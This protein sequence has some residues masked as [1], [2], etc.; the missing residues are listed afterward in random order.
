M[1]R[2]FVSAALSLLLGTA[3]TLAASGTINLASPSGTVGM[4]TDGTN[5]LNVGMLCGA[6]SATLYS[7]CVNQVIVN[8]SGQMLTMSTLTGTLP[9]FASPPTIANTSFGIS[10]TLPAFASNPTIA[11]TSFGIS[12]TLPAFASTPTVTLGA[13][14]SIAGKFGIDQTTPGTTNG[15][16]LVACATG[17]CGLPTIAG[18]ALVKG[19][20]A[21][22][23]GTTS[24]QV[25]AA[26]SSQHLY[27][28]AIHCN[29][30]GS[31][32][33]LVNIQDGSGGTTLDT[34]AAGATFGGDNRNGGSAPLFWTTAGNA[35]FAADVTTGASVIC[36]ASGY[37][38]AN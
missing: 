16:D 37:S 8:S 38:S 19:V 7:T 28:T 5:L 23:T 17:V 34:L 9:A 32:A 26:V 14:S 10:G 12:G 21:A 25:I 30:S 6:A 1:R 24:T 31:T 18:N 3:P 20:T 27:V 2:L 13:G 22:M 33:T 15:V 35:L 4:G 36:Q 11:N 29:N